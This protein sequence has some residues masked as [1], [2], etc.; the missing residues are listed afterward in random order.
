MKKGI[1][2]LVTNI[3][4]NKKYVGQTL[5]TFE[6]RKRRH[7]KNAFIFNYP[8][9]FYQALRKYGEHNFIWSI[10]EKDIDEN[11]LDDREIF[12][13]KHFDSFNNGYN[14][15]IGGYTIRGYHHSQEAKDKIKL[16]LRGKSNLDHYVK[17]YGEEKGNNMYNQYIESMKNR[18]GIKRLDNLIK[19]YGEIEGKNKYDNMIEKIKQMR[20]NKG[21]T[22]T[23]Q[24]LINKYGENKGKEIYNNFSNK[25]KNKK[26]SNET[27]EKKTAAKV[28]YWKLNKGKKDS[29]ETRNKKRDARYRYLK[30]KKGEN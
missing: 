11:L 10:L 12:W 16:K 1:I 19:K 14:M 6:Y 25:M 7:L 15:T 20:K 4:N 30:N 28:Q 23:L 2:Y 21:A 8:M 24:S 27:K 18:K 5:T 22:N 9:K 29:E 17:R 3:L 13:I 26:D